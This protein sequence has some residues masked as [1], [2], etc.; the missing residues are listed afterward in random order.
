MDKSKNSK[1]NYD[2]DTLEPFIKINGYQE[3]RVKSFYERMNKLATEAEQEANKEPV[4][5]QATNSRRI[6]V[7][8][9]NDV[10]RDK[11]SK[12]FTFNSIM[13]H[14][15]KN[16]GDVKEMEFTNY[17]YENDLDEVLDFINNV[18]HKKMGRKTLE[19]HI[20]YI[21]STGYDLIKPINT[22]NGLAYQLK[23]EIDGGYYV[24]IP[25][26]QLKELLI[27]ANEN[28]LKIYIFLKDYIKVT[29]KFV[30]MDRGFI[31]RSIGL[32]DKSCKNLNEISTM[33]NMLARL[34]YI[35]IK[36]VNEK[37]AVSETE[38]G[39]RTINSYRLTT[40]DEWEAIK[41]RAN[42]KVKK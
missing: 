14:S 7:T 13:I 19:K 36:T 41:E 32:S 18:C 22:P 38:W 15:N 33:L 39:Y 37:Y 34:G 5:I 12:Q 29:D 11:K 23:A 8:A 28:M 10:L 30:T 4:E 31:A 40:L 16:I 25:Y 27:G 2:R 35:E 26:C 9:H 21:M 20:K 24:T 1:I 17:I 3:E 42:G 6:P